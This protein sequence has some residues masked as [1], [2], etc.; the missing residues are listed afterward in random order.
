MSFKPNIELHMRNL[1]IMEDEMNEYLAYEEYQKIKKEKEEARNKKSRVILKKN[2]M[3]PYEFP[4]SP[5]YNS[6]TDVINK[7]PYQG[8]YPQS[9][10]Y[11]PEYF[12]KFHISPFYEVNP[13]D[14]YAK[15]T[16]TIAIMIQ[17]T[18][19]KEP[20]KLLYLDD[21]ADVIKNTREFIADLEEQIRDTSDN[22]QLQ[23][24][25]NNTISF[26]KEI[27]IVQER[28]DNYLAKKTNKKPRKYFSD[29]IHSSINLL[30]PWKG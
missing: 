3:S 19:K 4:R 1:R 24:Y 14:D 6:I 11:I 8:S 27:E 18:I 29:L 5:E 13:I 15:G 17:L 28:I 20:W 12:S 16:L 30:Q 2:P 10:T 23:V 21:Y 22:N 9:L 26:L 25:R 7:K